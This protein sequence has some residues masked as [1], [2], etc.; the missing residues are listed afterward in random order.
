MFREPYTHTTCLETPFQFQRIKTDF[1]NVKIGDTPTIGAGFWA[2][3]WN[4]LSHER[5]TRQQQ[6]LKPGIPTT[7]SDFADGL[8][9]VLGDCIPTLSGYQELPSMQKLGLEKVEIVSTIR[10]VAMSG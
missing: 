1:L 6:D 5:R 8:R 9:N 7:L 2:E 4:Q 10:A 3:E